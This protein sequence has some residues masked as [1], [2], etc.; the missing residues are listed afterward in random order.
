MPYPADHPTF[1]L[2]APPYDRLLALDDREEFPS[3]PR[4][5]RGAALIWC[6]GGEEEMSPRVGGRQQKF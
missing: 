4:V 3:D 6:V 1:L 2:L 5:F